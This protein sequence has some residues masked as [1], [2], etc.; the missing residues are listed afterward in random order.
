M[1]TIRLREHPTGQAR[2]PI[3]AVAIPKILEARD[4]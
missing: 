4:F 3:I 1:M 2:A